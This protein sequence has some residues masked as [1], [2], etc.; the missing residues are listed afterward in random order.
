MHIRAEFN[1]TVLVAVEF[2]GVLSDG[3]CNSLL[4]IDITFI[5]RAF[6]CLYVL[7]KINVSVGASLFITFESGFVLSECH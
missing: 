4:C 3:V 6:R 5:A 7:C 1:V 2:F